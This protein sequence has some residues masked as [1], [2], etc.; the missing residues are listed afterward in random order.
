M[1]LLDKSDQIER[2]LRLLTSE[3]RDLVPRIKCLALHARATNDRTEVRVAIRTR[4]V[5]HGR[6]NRK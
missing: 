2:A 4:M 3:T 1:K 6:E 5:D